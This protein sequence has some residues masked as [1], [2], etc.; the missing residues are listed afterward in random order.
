MESSISNVLGLTLLLLGSRGVTPVLVAQPVQ[1]APRITVRL[2]NYT[3]AAEKPLHEAK[4]IASGVFEEIA[5]ELTW[6]DCSP[7]HERLDSSCQHQPTATAINLRL[8]DESADP[9]IFECGLAVP[10]PPG[11][12]SKHA[13]VFRECVAKLGVLEDSTRVAVLGHMFAHEIGHLLLGLGSHSAKGIMKYPWGHREIELA[14]KGW[15]RFSARQGERIRD[16]VRR[17]IR[18][19]TDSSHD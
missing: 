14:D 15:L 3:N 5:V 9:D 4:E 8:A 11:G 12:F 18:A 1:P 17:R 2:F 19:E 7:G 10:A 13:I 6:L 16:G